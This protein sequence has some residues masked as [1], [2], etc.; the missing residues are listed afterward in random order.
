MLLLF[1]RKVMSNSFAT[2]WTIVC[3]APLS[4]GFPRQEYWSKFPFPSPRDFPN[5][6]IEPH[7]SYT[8]G[9]FFTAEP[10]GTPMKKCS[11]SYF[12]CIN[13]FQL[14]LFFLFISFLS[15][16]SMSYVL[17]SKFFIHS[18]FQKHCMH[19]ICYWKRSEGVTLPKCT[20]SSGGY[21][22]MG[23]YIVIITQKGELIE[24]YSEMGWVLG[25]ATLCFSVCS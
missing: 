25:P 17:P 13:F 18:S 19:N 15:A 6:G 22:Y 23:N 10:W 14:F 1:G 21:N 5:P 12:L 20:D 16:S 8:A 4:M 7:V 9:R 2:P 11:S 3:Q 24:I